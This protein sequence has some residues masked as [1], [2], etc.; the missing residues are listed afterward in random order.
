LHGRNGFHHL[1]VVFRQIFESFFHLLR[2]RLER[3]EL[4]AHL[5]VGEFAASSESGF[6]QFGKRIFHLFRDLNF[7]HFILLKLPSGVCQ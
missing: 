3:G 1:H 4:F 5:V 2:A 6:E 7:G